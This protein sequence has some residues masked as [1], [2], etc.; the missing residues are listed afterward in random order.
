MASNGNSLDLPKKSG[1]STIVQYSMKWR[2]S[3]PAI[4]H[5]MAESDFR[6]W[7]S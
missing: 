3:E 1:A 7:V 2:R 5:M 6:V 4:T